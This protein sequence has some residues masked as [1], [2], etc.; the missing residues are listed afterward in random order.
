MKPTCLS[1]SLTL[2]FVFFL[3]APHLRA[4]IDFGQHVRPILAEYCIQCHGPDEAQRQADLRL[5]VAPQDSTAIVPGDPD[6]S[7]L[8]SRILSEDLD[9]RMPPPEMEK[10]LS[11]S[12]IATLRQWIAEGARY[13]GHWAFAAIKSPKVPA[14]KSPV[15]TDID[16]FIVA[17]LEAQGLQL[18]APASRAQLIRRASFDLT[19]LP[20]TPEEVAAFVDDPAADAFAKVVDR[21]LES[22][23]YGERWGRLWLDIARY[24]DT[25]GGSAIGFTRFPFS[26]TYRDYVIRAFNSDLPYNQFIL[27]QLAADQL[28]LAENDPA[29]AAVGFLTVGMQ[30][31]SIHDLIDDQIDVVTRGLMGMTVACS[32]CHDHKFDPIPTTDYYA[33]Y[34]TFASS[35]APDNLPVLGEPQPSDA[36]MDYQRQL[37]RRQTIYEDMARD[38]SEMMRGRLR[39]QV[40]MYLAELAKGTPEQDI[41]AAFLSYRTDDI[42]PLVLNRW[43]SYLAAMPE[44]DPVFGPW[45][46]MSKLPMDDFADQCQSMVQELKAANGDPANF[47]NTS[48]LAMEG[49]AWNP[50]VLEALEKRK[51]A[52]MVEVAEAYGELFAAVH[53]GW[54]EA[55][56]AGSLEAQVGETIFTDED[57]QHAEVNSSI[58]Q[59]LRRHL[60]DAESPTAVPLE[61]AVRLLNRTVADTLG[62]KRGT[63]HDLHL[64][65]PGSPPRG[66]ILQ[67]DALPVDHYVFLRGNPL[68]RSQR[69]TPHFLTALSGAA[70][71]GAAL[72]GSAIA[73]SESAGTE[74]AGGAPVSFADGRRR[75]DLAQSIVAENNPLTRRV[76]ANW[77]WRNHFGVG[78]VRTPDDLG[79]RGTPPTHPELLDYLATQLAQNRWSIKHMHRLIMLSNVY[80]Q[81]A[82][83]EV[84][85]REVD[86]E[87]EL[88]WR[89][90]R[91]RLD[92]ESM[93]DA[94]LAVTNEL[95][96][97][98][99][100]GRPF[101]LDASPSVPR[102]SV[103]AFVNRDIISHLSSTFDGADPTSCTAERPDTIVPQQT[104][105]ALNSDFIQDRAAV[106]ARLAKEASGDNVV[107]VRWL[108]QRLYGRDPE[109]GEVDL[110]LKFVH[111]DDLWQQLAH[112]MLASNEFMYVD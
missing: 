72:S 103:Y 36:L 58:N 41:S 108:Y 38:Q 81:G 98:T 80:Q 75:L 63:I 64:N 33:L 85:S 25:H 53:R 102:R 112:A 15:V 47:A 60:Y 88:L 107:R 27:E 6:A 89:L 96:T 78:L 1:R 82:I 110:A 62:G 31:R 104:L 99:I 19:G 35:H 40:G 43:R 77:I 45:V 44:D 90:P 79:T 68:A 92:M 39:M 106:L 28:G 97:Q 69:V 52:S 55:L 16:R 42:R 54:L 12:Q 32:R 10:H 76:V 22:P 13:E 37:D 14:T 56:L 84:R 3:A 100:G 59:Q 66:M 74:T 5:D 4:E 93:R 7:E 23:R 87:N 111:S 86:P 70:L 17:K 51:P 29:L 95:D 61:Q 26:Y 8:L 30:F 48:S 83:E 24:A 34:A 71:S 49:P 67:E 105:Y 65:A 9:S 91:H 11:A 20:P 21:L 109:P 73:G 101:E 2:A 18:T 50:R 57:P 94:M 46:R